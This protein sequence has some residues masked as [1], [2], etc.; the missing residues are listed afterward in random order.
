LIIKEL[1]GVAEID[2]VCKA[3]DGKEVEEITKKEIHKALRG[4]IAAEQAKMDL[5]SVPERARQQ[6]RREDLKRRPILRK[7]ETR[8]IRR[9]EKSPLKASEKE[10]FKS[11]LDDLM[12]TRGA[13]ILDESLNVMGKVPTTELNTTIQNVSSGIYAVILDGA[14]DQDL[15]KTAERVKVRHIVGMDAR[16]V[17]HMNTRVNIITDDDL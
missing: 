2:F 11:I 1:L 8:P 17:K 9:V 4:K 12:G 10:K 14:I 16:P 5:N 6:H 13:F 3:P 15:V 7:V